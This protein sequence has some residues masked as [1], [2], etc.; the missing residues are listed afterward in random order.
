MSRFALMPLNL[1]DSPDRR[2]QA[3]AI[4]L[5]ASWFLTLDKDVLKKAAEKV[6]QIRVCCPSECLEEISI[7]LFLR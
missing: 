3:E 1:K 6:R 7:S 5:N 4:G 2:H